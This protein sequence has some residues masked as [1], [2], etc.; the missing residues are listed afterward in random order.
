MEKLPRDFANQDRKD[1]LSVINSLRR[2]PLELR[3]NTD[4]FNL[5]FKEWAADSLVFKEWAADSKEKQ[6]C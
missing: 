6:Q 2:S 4:S 3:S 5:V 1:V